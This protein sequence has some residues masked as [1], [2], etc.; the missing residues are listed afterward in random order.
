MNRIN[1]FEKAMSSKEKL[2]LLKLHYKQAYSKYT[3]SQSCH[4]L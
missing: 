4:A 1:Q 2:S 3:R